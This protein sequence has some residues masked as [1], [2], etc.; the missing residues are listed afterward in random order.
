MEVVTTLL[1]LIGSKFRK[2]KCKVL[3]REGKQIA[4]NLAPLSKF[5]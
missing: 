5:C 3:A 2:K 1:M 4:D